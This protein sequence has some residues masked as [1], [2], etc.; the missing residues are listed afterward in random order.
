MGASERFL[1]LFTFLKKN[2]DKKVMVFMSACNSVKFHDELL[3]Y[4]DIPVT[5]IHGHKKQ[6]A[7]MSTFYSFC[8]AEKGIMVCTDVAARGLDIPK[9]DWIVQFDPP[10]DPKEYIHRVGRTARGADGKGKALL[11]LMPEEMQ[12]L[13]YLKAAGVP[14][15]EYTFPANKVSNIQSQLERIIENNYHLH[16]SSRDAYRSYLHAYAAHSLKTC[17]QVNSLD[18]QKV[19]KSFGFAAPWIRCHRIN[20]FR[21]RTGDPVSIGFQFLNSCN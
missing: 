7:R 9:V 12:F 1:L 4:I 2:S 14:V 11:F 17:F 18:L 19:A 10:D 13:R 5:C 16:R 6:A 15:N 20:I 3:N 8:S 21:I